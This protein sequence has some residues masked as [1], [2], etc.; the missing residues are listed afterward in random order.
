MAVGDYAR[1]GQQFPIEFV[2]YGGT[3]TEKSVPSPA[4]AGQPDL[5][6]LTCLSAGFCA[7][8]GFGSRKGSSVVPVPFMDVFNGV[9]WTVH[10]MPQ[11]TAQGGL[12]CATPQF[13][14]AVASYD[15]L[16]GATPG[17]PA[18]FLDSWDGTAWRIDSVLSGDFELASVS[19]PSNQ[20]CFAAGTGPITS[21]AGAPSP[22]IARLAPCRGALVV[23]ARV[24][25]SGRG[26][27]L[28]AAWGRVT[29]HDH[30]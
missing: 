11:P 25:R 13:C 4:S 24:A 23:A 30:S 3:W 12:S 26:F 1:G 2:E 27:L 28:V 16:T 17:T 7:A 19:C 6:A 9:A 5:T 22:V 10:T 29:I 21:S 14:V 15:P 20:A 18:G 8:T